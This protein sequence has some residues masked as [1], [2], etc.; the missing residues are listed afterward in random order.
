LALLSSLSAFIMI[1]PRVYFAMA[2]DRLFFPF[3]ANVHPRYGVPGRSIV[4]QGAIAVLMATIGSFEQLLI[5]VGFALGLFPWL[6]VAGLF[7]ARR[8]HIGDSSAV[9]VWGYPFIPLFFLSSTLVLMVIA[10]INRPLESS[11]AVLTVIVGIPCYLLWVR[12]A[13]VSRKG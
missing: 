8:K 13:K 3:A 10:Y 6:A 11:A 7:I 5:Y 2:R 4:A 1:G 9:K 12:A